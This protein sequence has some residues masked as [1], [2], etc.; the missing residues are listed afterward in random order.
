MCII[1][2]QGP[3]RQGPRN[4]S[5]ARRAPHAKVWASTMKG[6]S[7]RR[8]QKL[9]RMSRFGFHRRLRLCHIPS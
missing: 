8:D 5:R 7:Q 9:Q 4:Q 6:N 2:A 1:V 3:I